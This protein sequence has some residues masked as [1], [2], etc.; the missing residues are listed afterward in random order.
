MSEEDL[1][2]LFYD[3]EWDDT[4][5][6]CPECGSPVQSAGWWDDPSS[7]GGA[8]IGT[9]YRCTGESCRWTDSV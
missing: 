2:D 7:A 1:D 8:C 6:K 4:D 3:P 9:Q 5:R